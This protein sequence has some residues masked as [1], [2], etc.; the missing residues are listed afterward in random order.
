MHIEVANCHEKDCDKAMKK[1]DSKIFDI[2]N[3]GP[4]PSKFAH[5]PSMKTRT[6]LVLN[7]R[8]MS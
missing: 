3:R 5:L 1:W 7:L 2:K 4:S 6:V 8:S